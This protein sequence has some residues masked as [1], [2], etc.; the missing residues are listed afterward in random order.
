MTR[1]N[2]LLLV[3]LVCS[4]IYLVQTSYESRRL[5]A[6]LERERNAAHQLDVEA[7]GLDVARRAYATSLRV[8]RVAREELRM[9]AATPAVTEYVTDPARTAAAA[10]GGRP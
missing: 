2:L 6:A 7:E 1:L 4:A 9:R 10:Q 8:E 5:Y 3:V